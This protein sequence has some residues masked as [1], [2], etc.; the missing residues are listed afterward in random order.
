MFSVLL[1][2]YSKEIP[3]NLQ[4]SLDS[5]INQSLPPTEIVLVKDGPLTQG[6]EN[7]ISQFIIKYPN[8]FNIVSLSENKGLGIALN[9]GLKYCSNELIARMDTD[10]IAYFERFEKQYN[11]FLNH[12]HLAVLGT[13]VQEFNVEKEDLGQFRTPPLRHD[14]ILKYSTYRNPFNHPSVMFKKSVILKVGS[15]ASM[16]YFEDYYLW[17]R[18]LQANY[19]V[20]NLDEP[21]LHFRIGNDMI[22]RR[23]GLAY[24]KHELRFL[25]RVKELGYITK[26]KF[27]ISIFLK[28]PLRLLPKK[29]LTI[30]Y[31]KTLRNQK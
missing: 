14:D 10:D 6:L 8:L 24:L 4:L 29:L 26:S 17:I 18:V 21:L 3:E 30:I 9:E 22:G 13:A 31:S 20:A 28:A 27:I 25:K 16:P 1:S 2:I 19:I 11:Y 5:I 7:V 23:I 12:P 15:Y